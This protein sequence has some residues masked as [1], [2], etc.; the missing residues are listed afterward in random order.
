MNRQPMSIRIALFLALTQGLCLAIEPE[1]WLQ[2]GV[3]AFEPGTTTR[4]EPL[5]YA[6]MNLGQLKNF[7]KAA[8]EELNAVLP[9]G[10]GSA[11]NDLVAIWLAPPSGDR[12]DHSMVNAGQL[13]NVTSL[14][15][16]RLIANGVAFDYPWLL[17]ADWESDYA[18]VNIGQAKALFAFDLT[19]DVDH[20]GLTLAQEQTAS[21]GQ[22]TSDTDGDGVIDGLDADPLNP[23]VSL[24]PANPADTTAPV[25]TLLRPFE[26]VL[27][28]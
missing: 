24:P 8:V 3:I 21:T 6:A 15:Y 27:N 1:W 14:V 28:P 20:D 17:S 23:S 4:R 26:A 19:G 25:I 5:D 11:L 9:N 2:R 22:W 13:K 7:T 18:S 10:A 12:Q 16:Q